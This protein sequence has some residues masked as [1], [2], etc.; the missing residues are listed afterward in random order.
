MTNTIATNTIIKPTTKPKNP[1]FSSGPTAKRPGWSFDALGGALIGRSH[2]SK[3]GK[4]KLQ[5]IIDLTRETLGV[6]ADYKIAI[7]A[8]SDTGAVELAL[9]NL[10]GA[11]PVDVF[12]WDTFGKDWVTDIVEELKLP[13]VRKF[14]SSTYGQLPDLTQ[15]N[16]AHD[17]VFTW[18]GTTS[19][20]KI[21]N[22]DWISNAREG[23]TI[24]DATSAVYAMPL[25]WDKLDVV[26]YSWQKV[27]GGEGA[28]G[29]IILSPRAIKR[30]ETHT[31]TWPLP[32]TF[33]IVKKGKV[34]EA[35]FNGEVINTPSMICIEDALDA[36]HWVKSIGGAKAMVERNLANYKI[37][38]DWIE[39]TPWIDFL[40]SDPATRSTTSVCFV[41]NDP[42]YLTLN[43]EGRAAF[44]KRVNALL[45]KEN[46]ALDANAYRDAPPG[47]RI[48]AGSTVESSD[49]A[50]V[51][52]WIE[53]AFATAK[54]EL[55]AAA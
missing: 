33:R 31:P 46:A 4:A 32:K 30:L 23:L 14:V 47:L 41:F 43:E 20:V 35:F 6:P 2:R 42:D 26:T 3:E 22:A 12:A 51:L 44:A 52:P 50:A 53:W 1:G 48:W 37:L 9:W 36:L 21:P 34:N 16:F 40:A 45:E 10:L 18:N 29:M 19:G 13:N 25:P 17:I 54:S 27:L 7:T 55:R 28:H 11:R 24:C 49:I 8:A 5:Q 39:R 38:A 15:A